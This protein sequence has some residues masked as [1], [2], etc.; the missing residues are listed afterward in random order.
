MRMRLL[1]AALPAAMWGMALTLGGCMPATQTIA[2]QT[3]AYQDIPGQ[4]A[5]LSRAEA[6]A[7]LYGRPFPVAPVHMPRDGALARPS[8]ATAEIYSSEWKDLEAAREARLR[9]SSAICRC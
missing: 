2:Y 7:I 6:Y 5:G 4:P 1:A 8:A 9:R 3:I